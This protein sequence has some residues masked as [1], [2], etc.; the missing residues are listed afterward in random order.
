[1]EYQLQYRDM[2]AVC[3][4]MG[5]ELISLKKSDGRE[6]I[7]Q[8]D[9]NYWNGR[10]PHLFPIVGSLKDS[11]TIILGKEY[12]IPKHGFARRNEFAVV[13]HTENQI[14]FVLKSNEKI[15]ECYPFLFAFYVT[16][17]LTEDGFLTEY[18]IE[19]LDSETM[20]FGL[21]GHTAFNCPMEEGSL[22]SDY[23]VRFCE[24]E[25]HP[26][27]Q[28]VEDDLGGLLYERGIRKEYQDFSVIN[29]NYDIFRLDALIFSKLNSKQVKL[30]HKTSGNGVEVQ[31]DG[32][33]S[34]GI[35]TPIGKQAPFV[36]IEPWSIIPDKE[37]TNG[38]FK[39]KPAITALNPNE[40]AQFSYRVRLLDRRDV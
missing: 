38:I 20:L 5:A 30:V 32:F 25:T 11:K 19:N 24:T 4:T 23:E 6:V 12:T 37:D 17:T 2:K 34:L 1:M 35:W 9:P 7:W 31:M 16:H 33:A 22:F 39:D 40:T 13:S 26:V 18:R 8:G 14:T 28:C 21:G 15:K 29:L 27:Y 3:T 36:C 10:N